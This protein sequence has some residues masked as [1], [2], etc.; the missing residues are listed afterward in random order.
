MRRTYS[1]WLSRSLGENQDLPLVVVKIVVEG[2]RARWIET[3][4]TLDW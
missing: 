2:L 3:P 1:T 4:R